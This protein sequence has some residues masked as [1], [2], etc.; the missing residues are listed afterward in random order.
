MLS[1]API[2]HYPITSMC[3]VY[4]I[5]SC[6]MTYSVIVASCFLQRSIGEIRSQFNKQEIKT[7][8]WAYSWYKRIALRMSSRFCSTSGSNNAPL[9]QGHHINQQIS[10]TICVKK[11]IGK[12]LCKAK[13]RMMCKVSN[14]WRTSWLKSS[15]NFSNLRK[16]YIKYRTYIPQSFPLCCGTC[17]YL[18]TINKNHNIKKHQFRG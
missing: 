5:Q 3:T 9:E 11:Q 2:S 12:R 4:L 13:T 1:Y 16:Q 7:V 17:N 6:H 15:P 8:G 18:R 14:P 10:K